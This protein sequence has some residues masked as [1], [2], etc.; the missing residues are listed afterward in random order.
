MKPLL[1]VENLRVWFPKETSF[2]GKPRTWIK[3]VD[4]VRFQLHAGETLGLVGES[5]SGKTTTGFAVMRA[6]HPREGSI[7]FCPDG[8]TAH[9]LS[10]MTHKELQPFRRHMQMIFQ[11][12]FSSLN[13]RMTVLQIVSEPLKVNGVGTKEERKQRVRELIVEAGLQ[14]EFLN[15]Y[16]HA[17][18]GGQRQRIVIARALA[19]QPKMIVC[20]EPVS[21]LDVS[22]QAQILNLMMELKDKYR[23]AYLFVAHDLEVVRHIADRVAVMY[24][25]RLVED[26]TK[27]QV[28]DDPFHPY[29]RSLLASSPKPDPSHRS[30]RN[31]LRG[32]V[33]DPS[34]LP[35]GCV[36]HPRCPEAMKC[37]SEI[38][39]AQT[40]IDGRNVRCLLYESDH[41]DQPPVD[42]GP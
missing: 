24:A 15:R 21:A 33:P 27:K 36:F 8:K 31:I 6:L 19:L 17:F 32:E 3:A 14:A 22:V 28:F 18:S 2:F 16:P 9:D 25:G 7:E 30:K 38:V 26:G 13:P 11:D 12:P 37:C 23:L 29:T 5:G 1:K 34:D 41:K 35:S 10:R 40:N 42:E 4:D 39:P 20:D